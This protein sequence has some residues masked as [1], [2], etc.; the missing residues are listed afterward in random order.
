MPR[1]SDLRLERLKKLKKIKT[2]RID[3]YPGN[4]GRD[5]F[6]GDFLHAFDE[7]AK[8]QKEVS[9]GG[10]I[11][12]IRLHGK[13][14]FVDIQDETGKVQ[15]FLS[16]N[17]TKNYRFFTQVIDEGDI[18]E[19]RG[20]AY[21]SKRGEKS[22]KTN[23]TRILAKA[24]RPLPSKWHGLKD[25][26][27]RYRKRYLD[28]LFNQE[29]KERF[30][31]TARIIK[32][33]RFF[34]DDRGFLEVKTPILQPLAGGALAKPFQTHL[35]ALDVDLYLRIAP[36]LYLKRLLVGGFEKIYELGE[37]FR[38]EGIDRD[39]N[40]EFLMLEL[41]WAYQDWEGLM[42]F[43]REWLTAVAAAIPTNDLRLTTNDWER[44]EFEELFLE[45]TGMNYQKVSEE[46]ML[47]FGKAKKLIINRK[48]SKGKIADEI[49]KKIVRPKLLNPTFI[50]KLPL[51]ISPF[52]KRLENDPSRTAR[53]V[54]Y[55]NG[56]E[57]V[58]GFS[59]LNDPQDQEERF[60][61]QLEMKKKGDEEITEYDRDYIEALEYGM[62]PAAG[63]GLGVTRF[64]MLLT[65]APSV[66]EAMLFPLMRPK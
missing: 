60:K 14:A 23:E 22:L 11:A 17:D 9:I 6:I 1:L 65:G 2:A 61:M 41:Y 62:P 19:A 53:F 28:L 42:K 13:A 5:T 26:E 66:R 33:L 3:P 21:L 32:E 58:N 18:I 39:H 47:T 64:I 4:S 46:D 15:L 54:L 36:E 7:L 59:E 31:K 16:D 20:N 35:N 37:V 44:K 56:L 27:E 38:N 48:L 10:R 55:V 34:L 51:D 8:S 57:L 30:A 12:S 25:V 49:F 52:A 45:H 24:L 43:T 50:T 29:V 63:L 40:P